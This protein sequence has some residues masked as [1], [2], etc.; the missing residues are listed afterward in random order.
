MKNL[1]KQENWKRIRHN[2]WKT[3]ALATLTALSL[4][5]TSCKAPTWA[6]IIKD[7][8]KIEVAK[9]QLSLLIEERRELVET[10]NQYLALS[11]TPW[12]DNLDFENAKT[13]VFAQI[14]K[15]EKDINKKI[16]EINRHKWKLTK[17]EL[18]SLEASPNPNTPMD[19]NKYNFTNNL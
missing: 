14:V 17:H 3:Y 11:G 15:H 4:S 13:Q 7:K 8:Q 10:Y 18:K 5:L 16:K 12:Y 9:N 1:E 19:P 2:S 6:D